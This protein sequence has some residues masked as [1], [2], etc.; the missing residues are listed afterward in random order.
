MWWGIFP[1]KSG[2]FFFKILK[3]EINTQKLLVFPKKMVYLI[4]FIGSLGLW[5]WSYF[6]LTWGWLNPV[7]DFCS[8]DSFSPRESARARKLDQSINEVVRA[9]SSTPCS[10][11]AQRGGRAV[12]YPKAS[13]DSA[14]H[15]PASGALA[16]Y[17]AL[18]LFCKQCSFG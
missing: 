17:E 4:D 5:L 11:R 16:G 13:M 18:F 2:Q 1:W 3:T 9:F 7:L 8:N 10:R 14:T 15:S 6:R 12:V